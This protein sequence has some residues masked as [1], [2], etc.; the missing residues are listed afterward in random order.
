MTMSFETIACLIAHAPYEA[1]HLSS[2]VQEVSEYQRT[3]RIPGWDHW[4]E[5]NSINAYLA[6]NSTGRLRGRAWGVSNPFTNF[7][8]VVGAQFRF[9]YLLA[10]ENILF[11]QER[12]RFSID[13]ETDGRFLHTAAVPTPDDDRQPP[14]RTFSQL[15]NTLS[16]FQFLAN[17]GAQQIAADV[18][19]Q[20]LF[21][22]LEASQA[23]EETIASN[24]TLS[25][26]FFP[27]GQ[28]IIMFRFIR[29]VLA[30]ATGEYSDIRIR[31]SEGRR[32]FRVRVSKPRV[33]R[34]L[35]QSDPCFAI[36]NPPEPLRRRPI[37][38][39]GG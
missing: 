29:G 23:L 28:N 26:D 22:I 4:L 11:P 19:R 12:Y 6:N 38:L 36:L 17:G 37:E 39:P 1:D 8:S 13:V 10:P 34:V 16:A 25:I 21:R 7:R 5:D 27:N 2:D 9:E 3:S 20:D 33:Q 31:G 18:R 15:D 32:N 14:A 30:A 35:E 24:R